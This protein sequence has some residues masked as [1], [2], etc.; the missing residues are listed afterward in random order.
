MTSLSQPEH[1]YSHT[2]IT[3][4]SHEEK[5]NSQFRMRAFPP[6]Q[7]VTTTVLL[8]CR[9]SFGTGAR[10]ARSHRAD[11][12]V[13][14]LCTNNKSR[15]LPML[16]LCT[17]LIFYQF[18]C[19]VCFQLLWQLSIVRRS[20]HVSPDRYFCRVACILFPPKVHIY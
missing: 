14:S 4:I 20:V 5:Y 1:T 15:R 10:G 8:P 17:C 13:R 11:F 3:F 6:P 7:Q 16:T 9:V 2:L 18:S 12:C 19:S